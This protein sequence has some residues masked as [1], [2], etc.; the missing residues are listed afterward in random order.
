M[1]NFKI[2]IEMEMPTQRPSIACL[3]KK[4][5]MKHAPE[6]ECWEGM[7]PAGELPLP[8]LDK[9]LTGREMIDEEKPK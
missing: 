3:C 6:D 8:T 5:H 1:H 7:L 4:C 9:T 2:E